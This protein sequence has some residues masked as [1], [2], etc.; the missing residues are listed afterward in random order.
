MTSLKKAVLVEGV[1]SVSLK[2]RFTMCGVS[3]SIT[4]R[5]MEH[6][7]IK[8]IPYWLLDAEV[9]TR[10]NAYVL[11]KMEWAVDP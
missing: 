10:S 2:D 4:D 1:L 5:P 8:R 9:G 7:T 3:Q 11:R 6:H